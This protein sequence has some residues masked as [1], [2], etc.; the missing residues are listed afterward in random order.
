M[1]LTRTK[2]TFPLRLYSTLMVAALL[3]WLAW[4]VWRP[5][6]RVTRPTLDVSSDTIVASTQLTNGSSRPRSV[7]IHF[8][9]G[10]QVMGTESAPSKFQL[11]ASRDVPAEVRARATQTV[12]CEFPHPHKQLP[13]L[14]DAQIASLK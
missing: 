12:S 4:Y 3:T 13:F 10:Y 9:L 1:S 8:E 14:A 6:V 7:T 5:P 2:A 11:I